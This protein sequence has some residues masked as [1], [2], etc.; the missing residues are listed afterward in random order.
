MDTKVNPNMGS[1]IRF[2]RNGNTI[3]L[4]HN[5][6]DDLVYEYPLES[7][8]IIVQKAMLIAFSGNKDFANTILDLVNNMRVD[9]ITRRL[10][11]HCPVGYC[12]FTLLEYT[13]EMREIKEATLE[14]QELVNKPKR[15]KPKEEL[16]KEWGTPAGMELD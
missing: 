3:T 13:K 10:V 7:E 4:V 16:N 2:I 14:Q 11:K 5:I 9:I 15:R 6:S 8:A 1:A 12:A